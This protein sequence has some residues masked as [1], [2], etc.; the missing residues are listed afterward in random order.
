ML[1]DS[2]EELFEEAPCGY[3]STR[4]DGTVIRVN[5]TFERWTGRGR[6]ELVG[7][8]RFQDLLSAGGRIYY[9]THYAPLL[10]MQGTAREVAFEIVRADGTVL[11]ALVNSILRRD[12]LGQPRLVSTTLFDATER[13]RYEEELLRGAERQ[14]EIGL[15][16]QRS[17][18]AGELPAA[19]GFEI[20]VFYAPA[21]SGTEIGGDW[22]DAFWLRAPH[23]LALV[24]GDVVG[25]GLTA[26]ATMGQLRS[27]I[28]ALA[29]V[30]LPPARLLETLDEYC[31]RHG[32]GA[33]TTMTYA[34]LDLDTRELRFA[35]AGHPPPLVLEPGGPPRFAWEGR[36][37]P[38]GV[39]L[40]AT[41]RAEACIPISG[42]TVIVL[43]TDGLVEHRR[44][45][46]DVGMEELCRLVDEHRDRALSAMA[47]AIV[48]GLFE[49][50]HSDD[51]CLLAVRAGA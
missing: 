51:R 6:E 47:D 9:E 10:L 2:A 46:V 26:A 1:E 21:A 48:R 41:S 40:G 34:E 28:R 30:E 12:E 37:L 4:L 44:R 29:A 17:L 24:V 18:L 11:P 45:P 43:Y 3:L 19:P 7:R 50:G 35:C 36:S 42:G 22:Y 8:A 39:L 32:I 13:R 16:L 31:R 33:M 25:R 27:A 14:Y 15:A 49:P 23:R 20:E 38:I 5:R